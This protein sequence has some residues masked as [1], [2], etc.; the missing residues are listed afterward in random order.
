MS[1]LSFFP[2]ILSFLCT[3]QVNFQIAAVDAIS[4]IGSR[5]IDTL[6]RTAEAFVGRIIRIEIRRTLFFAQLTT[7]IVNTFQTNWI[8]KTVS[9]TS[10]TTRMASSADLF[11]RKRLQK[12]SLV[13]SRPFRVEAIRTVLVRTK[14][15]ILQKEK[16]K[17]E[18]DKGLMRTFSCYRA[19]S[20]TTEFPS[21]IAR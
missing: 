20:L 1:H 4:R 9:D 3:H 13:W 8:V 6:S 16:R 15:S 17:R 18:V 7:F 12:A 2:S 14:T 11:G 19:F 10:S 5:A 21:M